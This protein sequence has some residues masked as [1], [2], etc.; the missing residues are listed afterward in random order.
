MVDFDSLLLRP[1]AQA[2]VSAP[3]DSL[4]EKRSDE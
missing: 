4:G 3:F 2:L 1:V